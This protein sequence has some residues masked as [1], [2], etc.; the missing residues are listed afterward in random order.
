MRPQANSPHAEPTTQGFEFRPP[1]EAQDEGLD[2]NRESQPLIAHGTPLAIHSPAQGLSSRCSRAILAACAGLLILLLAAAL[3]VILRRIDQLQLLVVQTKVSEITH[4][5][6]ESVNRPTAVLVVSPAAVSST[7]T[8]YSETQLTAA[9]AAEIPLNTPPMVTSD[10]HLNG[11]P[12]QPFTPFA[13]AT[14]HKS[15]F[16]FFCVPHALLTSFCRLLVLFGVAVPS[17]E[18]C[19]L[20]R[21][22]VLIIAVRAAAGAY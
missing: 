2:F 14:S 8:H 19:N 1:C 12:T 4:S 21:F 17:L 6:A 15:P 10:I 7:A 9:A 18:R 5:G 16:S 22:P 20:E 13:Y 3:L 11:S